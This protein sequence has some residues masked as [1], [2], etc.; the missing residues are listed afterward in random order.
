M[1][2]AARLAKGIRVIWEQGVILFKGVR[3][4]AGHGLLLPWFGPF[5]GVMHHF[6]GEDALLRYGAVLP[7]NLQRAFTAQ[8]HSRGAG[9]RRRFAFKFAEYFTVSFLRQ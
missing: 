7:V 4:D 5:G 1:S 9:K 6:A 3:R 8:H 2:G